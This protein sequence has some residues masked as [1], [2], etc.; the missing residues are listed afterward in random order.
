MGL[1]AKAETAERL[2]KRLAARTLAI[3]RRDFTV[4]P[5]LQVIVL[6]AL[7]KPR[8]IDNPPLEQVLHKITSITP[9]DIGIETREVLEL[10]LA[11][12]TGRILSSV[13]RMQDAQF[14][15]Q[16]NLQLDSH[17][18]F[19]SPGQPILLLWRSETLRWGHLGLENIT[20]YEAVWRLPMAQ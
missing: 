9:R 11:F 15:G 19:T 4:V 16:S 12:A 20:E 8:P 17:E 18:R 13:D 1:V 14:N 3:V 10:S 5:Y 2:H 6:P 7:E